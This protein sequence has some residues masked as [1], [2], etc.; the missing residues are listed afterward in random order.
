MNRLQIA[1]LAAAFLTTVTSAHNDCKSV[2]YK[3]V[4]NSLKEIGVAVTVEAWS[5]YNDK[6]NESGK[7]AVSRKLVK[8]QMISFT[9]CGKKYEGFTGAKNA[10]WNLTS[11]LANNLQPI[12]LAKELVPM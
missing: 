5:E 11:F 6:M 2:N 3:T 8:G 1:K 10:S 4:V 12:E 9:I 7:F